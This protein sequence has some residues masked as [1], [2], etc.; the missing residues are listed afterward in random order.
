MKSLPFIKAPAEPGTRRIGT[1]ATGIL[2]FPVLGGLTVGE[3]AQINELMSQEQS[4]FV[5]GA[6]IA[7]QIAKREEITISEAFALLEDTL[8]GRELEPAA[9]AIRLRH[10][11]Q[12]EAVGRIYAAAGQ[13]NMTATVTALIVSRLG[14]SDWT[15]ED[16][17]GMKRLLFEGIWALAQEETE[18][19]Q[20]EP[21]EP[22]DEETLGK[23]LEGSGRGR[24]RTGAASAGT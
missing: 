13:K 17:T 12:I 8:R 2:E 9:E 16:T 3:S 5:K 20:Q 22:A 10:A 4:A 23:P 15:M 6:Q 1:A 14:M 24:K 21:A 19:E 18:A 11:A 7:D